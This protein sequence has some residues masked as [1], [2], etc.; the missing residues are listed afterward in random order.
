MC[1]PKQSA[2]KLKENS[3]VNNVWISMHGPYYTNLCS[4]KDELVEKSIQRMIQSAQAVEWMGA[5]RIVFHPGFYT[6]YTPDEVY[7][8]VKYSG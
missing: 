8:N 7:E 2:L 6:N 4:N 5:D 1:I 3:E